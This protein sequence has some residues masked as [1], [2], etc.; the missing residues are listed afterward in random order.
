[1]QTV[2]TN[3]NLFFFVHLDSAGHPIPGTMFS[4]IKDNKTDPGY[5]CREGRL[6][7]TQMTVPAGKTRC[8]GP[9]KL[10]YFYRINCITGDIIPNSM[11]S[12]QG[13]PSNM[14]GILEYIIWN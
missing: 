6:P 9:N 14:Y 5:F 1:M 10:R 8:W 3:C 13:K 4:K 2:T 12:R 7:K 11:F